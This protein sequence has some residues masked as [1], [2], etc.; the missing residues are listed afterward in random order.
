MKDELLIGETVSSDQ[1][2]PVP[3]DRGEYAVSAVPCYSRHRFIFIRT[4]DVDLLNTVLNQ[5]RRCGINRAV[6]VHGAAA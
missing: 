2:F 3:L 1:D 5:V 6:Q 4:K